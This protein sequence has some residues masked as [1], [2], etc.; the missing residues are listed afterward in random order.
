MINPLTARVIGAPQMISQ[1]VS[2]IF[3][4]S[5]LPSGTWW[6]PGLSIPWYLPTSSSVCLVFFPP[7]LCLA[8]WFR[9]DLMNR[10]HVRTTAVCASLWSGGLCVVR[11]PAGSWHGLLHWWHGLCMS[12][13]VFWD[14]WYLVVAPHFHGM[15]S[16]LE[17]CCKG[18]W[19]TRIHK[20]GCDKEASQDISWN[21]EIYSC[22]SKL[23]STLS[24]LLLSVLSGQ[25]LR[26]WTFISYNWAQILEACDCLKLLSIYFNLCVGATGVVCHQLG[27]LGTDLHAVV[28][29][30]FVKT[31]D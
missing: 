19:F 22:H 17:F 23:V 7:S 9:P 20:D 5:P 1:P 27:L 30:G 8:R 6:N 13:V 2:S 10:R 28:C 31:L 21:W 3:L 26:L 16:S 15:Y 14:V 18:P 24:M 29:G 11:L 4:C 25:H 12:C